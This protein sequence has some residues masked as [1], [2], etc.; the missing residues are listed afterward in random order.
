MLLIPKT[1]LLS[2]EII[3]KTAAHKD[4]AEMQEQDIY[5]QESKIRVKDPGKKETGN[6]RF[7]FT[8][9]V[10]SYSISNCSGVNKW[11]G[12][13]DN[14]F[15]VKDYLSTIHYSHA[16]IHTLYALALFDFF[17]QEI[18]TP[19]EILQ[20]TYVSPIALLHSSG[21]YFY[22][23]KESRPT[24]V[25]RDGKIAEYLN[26]FTVIKEFNDE[27]YDFR[28]YGPG[29]QRHDLQKKIIAL[30]KKNFERKSGFSVQELRI[31]KRY[32]SSEK[33]TSE[34]IATG[35]KIERSTVLTYNKRILNKTE[36]LFG[37]RF[38]NAQKAASYFK[39]AHLI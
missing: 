25:T 23:K 32:A 14:R 3:N 1:R 39:A 7:H 34:K 30:A 37:Y 8:V 19:E 22:C 33:S 31:L 21:K 38:D 20:L 27:L 9:D 18:I 13:A 11:L 24:K 16:V 2:Q 26:E 10:F 6:E 12:Y 4:Q 17:A 15:F 28:V 35:F 29:G 5:V 36:D